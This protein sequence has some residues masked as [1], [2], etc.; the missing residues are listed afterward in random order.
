M[1][2][3]VAKCPACGANLDLE[4]D[5]DYFFCPHCGAKVL[6]ESDHIVV[7]H[8]TRTIDE[9]KIK[10]IELE[11]HKFDGNDILLSK[12][13][14]AIIAILLMTVVVPILSGTTNTFVF[15]ILLVVAAYF[16]YKILQSL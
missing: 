12:K 9:A 5:K 6:Q 16:V 11:H 1:G 13:L 15:I 14:V 7:E 2:L 10:E 3:T 4:T 8:V